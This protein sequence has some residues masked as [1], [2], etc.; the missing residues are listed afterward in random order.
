MSNGVSTR[1]AKPEPS[2]VV[3]KGRGLLAPMQPYVRIVIEDIKRLLRVDEKARKDRET[4]NDFM[5]EHF[6]KN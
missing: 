2:K 4:Y 5:E 6:K 3:S 1:P